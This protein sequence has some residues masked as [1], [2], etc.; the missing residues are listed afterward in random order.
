MINRNI[1]YDNTQKDF[2]KDVLINKFADNIQNNFIKL[3]GRKA[4]ESEYNSWIDTGKVIKNLI[5]LSGLQNIYV[6]FEYQVPYTQKR[7]DCLLFGKNKNGDGV[8]IHIEMKQWQNVEAL[9]VEGNFV[10][11]YV[12]GNQRKV[13]HPSQQVQGYHNYLMGFVEVFE[14]CDINLIGCAYCPNYNHK[15]GK[16]L[17]DIKYKKIIDKFPLYTKNDIEKL[18][19]RL[20]ELLSQEDGFDI[21]NKF[22]ESAIKPSR[23]LLDNASNVIKKESDFNLLDDQIYAR[24]VIIDKIKK[25]ENDNENSVIIVKGAP[26]TGK[27]VIALHIL[28]EFAGH[29]KKK[30]NIFFACKSKALI[31]AIKHKIERGQKIGSVNAKIL[32][33]NLNPFVPART[34]ENE[35][36]I[37]IIDEA[38]RIGEKSNHQ[39]TPKEYRTDMPQIEQ[40]IRCAKTSIF[41][42]DDKQNIRGAEIGSTKLIK[43]TAKRIGKDIE[44]IELTSQFRCNGSD[45]YLDWLEYVLGHSK[46]MVKKDDSFKFKICKSPQELYEKIKNKDSKKGISARLVAGYCWHWS[47]VLDENG[48]L[49]KDVKIGNFSMPWE[50]HLKITPP[51][52]YV[53]WYEW[54][55]KPEGIKQV[56]CIYTAQ[57]FEFDYIGVIIGPDLKYDK[58]NDCLIGDISKTKDSMLKRN[59]DNFDQYVKNIYRVLM[60]RG[61]KGCYV[62]F[63]DKD[64]E[65]FFRSRMKP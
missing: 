12:G 65:N 28:A 23:K 62:Y 10:E 14:T 61:M 24:N 31:E 20:K 27:T 15:E 46:K 18:A 1:I 37:L 19:N 51:K 6:S 59:K 41:F 40:L 64:V 49:I 4:C 5:E 11:T 25:A 9:S 55:Y 26:G 30:Y 38:H 44:E 22:M 7:I 52:G 57:G 63:V 58:E 2:F 43:E 33:T 21:F 60:S 34:N 8:I 29:E 48:Q 13:P 3:N 42:I 56:G 32:F 39:F 47:K 17:F 54:A 45:N 53:H 50:T 36:D 16:G 35:L